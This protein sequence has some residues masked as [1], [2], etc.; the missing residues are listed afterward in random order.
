MFESARTIARWQKFLGTLA[1]ATLVLLLCTPV[2]GHAVLQESTPA[3]NSTVKGPDVSIRLRFNSR[4]DGNRS[5]LTLIHPDGSTE[6]LKMGEQPSP[7]TLTSAASKLK[8][9][10]YKLHWQ[11]LATDGHITRGDIPFKVSG[12]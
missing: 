3:A 6:A 2:E 7:D 5:K 11:V 1:L 10:D 9:G 12:N 4:I 8:P